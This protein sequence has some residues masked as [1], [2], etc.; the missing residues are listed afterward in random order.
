MNLTAMSQR[1]IGLTIEEPRIREALV[2]EPT[3]G[4]ALRLA[5]Y[6]WEKT[7]QLLN[8]LSLAGVMVLSLV[9]VFPGSATLLFP[10][11]SRRGR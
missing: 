10:G 9:A 3:G 5:R 8:G 2:A 6:A 1:P 4:E 11:S 7:G